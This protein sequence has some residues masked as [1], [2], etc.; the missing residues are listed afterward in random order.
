VAAG[1]APALAWLLVTETGPHREAHRSLRPLP[2]SEIDAVLSTLQGWF[3]GEPLSDA[4]RAGVCAVVVGTAIVGGLALG[5]R[6][7]AVWTIVVVHL[8]V[9]LG[10]A[11]YIRRLPVGGRML[12]PIH[13]LVVCLSVVGAVVIARW[14]FSRAHPGVSSL[15]R[16]RRRSPERSIGGRRASATSSGALATATLVIALF[17][18]AGLHQHSALT[19]IEPARPPGAATDLARRLDRLAPEVAVF[20]NDASA[21]Y[22]T[23]GRPTLTVPSRLWQESDLPNTAFDGELADLIRLV[24]E[25]RAVVV[26]FDS[27]AFF[28]EAL[29]TPGELA[30]AGLAVI[31]IDGGRLLAADHLAPDLGAGDG[32]ADPDPGDHAATG[33]GQLHT[34]RATRPAA[35][36]S[37]MSDQ[38]DM[39]RP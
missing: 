15:A 31:P 25:G 34:T 6:A 32:A 22:L 29:V 28:N 37:R 16:R 7:L 5:R 39:P 14:L 11:A 35:S 26:L 4:V 3:F 38:R 23:T 17:A 36:G 27:M 9:V 24:R 2:D 18:L 21:V 10:S 20:S 33:A 19:S 1:S 30:V 8:A 13:P 12:M